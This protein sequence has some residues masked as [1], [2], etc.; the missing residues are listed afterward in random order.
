MIEFPCPMCGE[1][2]S[3]PQSLAGHNELC[4]TC[5]KL[6]RVP[7]PK[8]AVAPGPSRPGAQAPAPAEPSDRALKIAKAID[9]AGTRAGGLKAFC[10]RHRKL[11]I[12]AAINAAVLMGI[13]GWLL[14][15]WLPRP[16]ITIETPSR[17]RFPPRAEL[18]QVLARH[19]YYPTQTYPISNILRGRQLRRYSYCQNANFPE[20][21]AIHLWVPPDANA[22]VALSSHVN[23][24]ASQG[25]MKR[26]TARKGA[27]GS[28][29]RLAAAILE[30]ADRVSKVVKEL[31]GAHPGDAKLIGSETIEDPLIGATGVAVNYVI[32]VRGF[33]IE[34]VEICNKV[35]DSVPRG[36]LL[37]VKDR[38]W[39]SPD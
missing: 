14:P 17:G 25:A 13:L 33:Q 37:L 19:G 5:G 6:C 9:R 22:V 24:E 16:V 23:I 10:S 39:G 31:A 34:R 32:Q 29:A 12:F 30:H 7:M 35:S 2:L 36:V 38:S 1:I 3:V 11:L 18:A 26:A 21:T 28:D 27:F 8:P 20:S 4:P 15:G